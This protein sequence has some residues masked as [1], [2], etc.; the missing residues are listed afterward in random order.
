[1]VQS[2]DTNL[3]SGDEDGKASVGLKG[4]HV[5]VGDEVNDSHCPGHKGDL[6]LLISQKLDHL[7]GKNGRKYIYIKYRIE[8][9][10]SYFSNSP[11]ANFCFIIVV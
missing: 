6:V 2:A 11:F 8:F 7:Q 3:Q 4:S 5:Q 10:Y 9:S 1:M